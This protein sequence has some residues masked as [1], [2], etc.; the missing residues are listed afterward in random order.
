[1]YNNIVVLQHLK[2]DIL[3][4]VFL[5]SN[6]L[7]CILLHSCFLVSDALFETFLHNGS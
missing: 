6:L 7:Y 2:G 5:T 1:M 4:L 3:M